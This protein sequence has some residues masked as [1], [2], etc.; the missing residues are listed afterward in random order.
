VLVI[1]LE[2]ACKPVRDF[3][4]VVGVIAVL[5]N[6]SVEEKFYTELIA[7]AFNRDTDISSWG[8]DVELQPPTAS[9]ESVAA[10]IRRLCLNSG[11]DL[12][13]FNNLQVAG[14]LKYIFNGALSNYAHKLLSDA[15]PA[16]LRRSA[17]RSLHVLF[18]KCFAPRCAPH[19]SHGLQQ[20]LDNPINEVCYMFWDTS[21][22]SAAGPD[23]LWVMEQSLYLDNAACIES[24]LHGLGHAFYK[25][26][27][28]VETAIDK[29][30]KARPIIDEQLLAYAMDARRGYVN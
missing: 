10:A 21:P 3:L 5:E 11:E 22:L 30:L 14:G 19:L 9:P 8:W 29:F 6:A 20:A 26:E 27:T 28:F 1:V 25:N 18:E 24:G 4:E 15:V 2:Y 23:A 13:G 7:F 12:E 17:I 16:D